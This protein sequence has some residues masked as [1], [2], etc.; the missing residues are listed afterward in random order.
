PLC[1][2]D[3]TCCRSL[4]SGYQRCRD[5]GSCANPHASLCWPNLL[6]IVPLLTYI[7]YQKAGAVP[8]PYIVT[9]AVPSIGG[10]D[11]PGGV[12]IKGGCRCE[13]ITVGYIHSNGFHKGTGL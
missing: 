2:P 3:T 8:L 12:G 6:L 10:L 1:R 11:I 5:R 7:G 9:I 13:R 4:L